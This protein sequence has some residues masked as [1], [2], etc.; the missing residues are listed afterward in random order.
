MSNKVFKRVAATLLA[1]LLLFYVGLQIY[2]SNHSSI[3]TE[4]ATYMTASDTIETTGYIVRNET[5]LTSD[6]GGVLN[7]VL[8]D[9]ESVKGNGVVARIYAS[10]EDASAQNQISKLQ[11]EI[12]NLER[13][14]TAADQI[15]LSTSPDVI[16]GQITAQINQFLSVVNS[17]NYSGIG[18]ARDELTY[19]LN[20]RQIIT[21][22]PNGYTDR[23]NA[24]KS[25]LESMKTQAAGPIGTVNSPAAGYFIGS[26]DGYETSFSYDSVK[27]ITLDQLDQEPVQQP[28]ADNVVGKVVSGLNWYVVCKVSGTDSLQLEIGE[29]VDGITMPFASTGS[30]PAKVVAINQESRQSDAVVVL[31]CSYM[32]N[33]LSKVRKESVQIAV[34]THSG[35]MVNKKAIHVEPVMK[36]IDDG[37][38]RQVKQEVMVQGVYVL[39]GS[40]LVFKEIVP[41]STYSTFVLCDPNP[42]EDATFNGETIKLYDEVVVGGTDLYD[43]K[44]V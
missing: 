40:E 12:D 43:G 41:L 18:G 2:N 7:Y 16:D 38:G 35:I 31:E 3:Q 4:T 33:E 14:T 34:N 19:L 30:I 6:A 42:E 28:V 11:G 15:S 32:N 10:A 21:G 39:Y 29:K 5:Y 20:Q 17:G 36:V 8:E 24:L 27:E 26:T 1:V 25:Q 13:L 37:S 22:K 23:L 9:G 44:I